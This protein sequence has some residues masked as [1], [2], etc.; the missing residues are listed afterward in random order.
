MSPEK[1]R[2]KISYGRCQW[3]GVILLL[4]LLMESVFVSLC[5]AAE[6][7]GFRFGRRDKPY[8]INFSNDNRGWIVGDMGLATTTADGGNNWQRVSVSGEESLKDIFFVGDAG[9]IVGNGGLILHS[10]NGGKKWDKQA[11]GVNVV[12]LRVYFL[13]KEKG[14]TVGTDGTVLKT[15]NGGSSWEAVPL[16]WLKLLPGDLIEKGIMSINLYDVFFADGLSGWIVGDYG[17]VLHTTDGGKSWNLS[18]CG[19]FPALYSVFFKNKQEGWTVGQNGFFLKTTDGGRNWKNGAV[20]TEESLYRIFFRGAYGIIVGDHG[21]I[22]KTNDGGGTWRN[23]AL[24]QPPPL[25][26]LSS[27]WILPDAQAAKVIVI[28]KG[29]MVKTEILSR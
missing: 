24:K 15:V 6:D 7:S 1:P 8:A 2:G 26:W 18:Q 4:C 16:D 19:S 23:G 3:Q 27:A 22:I 12:L 11:S 9:W 20:K 13:D 14:F 17:T 10:G 25:P 5:A 21:I 29:M 28:G